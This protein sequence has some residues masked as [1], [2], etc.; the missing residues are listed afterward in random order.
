MKETDWFYDDVA[1]VFSNDLF[2]GVSQNEFAPR[3]TMSRAMLVTVLYR[4]H[5]LFGAEGSV[6][7]DYDN[8]FDDVP[9]GK[10]YTEAVKWAAAN[11]I[12]MGNGDGAFDPN[13]EITREQL[14]VILYR[15]MQYA[16]IDYEVTDEYIS[17]EDGSSISNFAK[18]AVQV[19]NKS[20]IIRGIGNGKIAPKNS[21]TRAEVAAMLHR[22]IEMLMPRQSAP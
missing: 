15:Y 5:T 7:A 10:Y 11:G 22:F 4:M 8:P 19:M 1:F 14:A 21:A 6:E 20:G 18:D 17:F 9:E 16:K 13:G 2:N 3:M 12:V